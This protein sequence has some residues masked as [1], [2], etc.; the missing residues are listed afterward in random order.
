[1]GSTTPVIRSVTT[2]TYM[3]VSIDASDGNRYDADLS[4]FAGVFC[5]PR[6]SEEWSQVSIDS[7]GLG[8]VWASRFEVHVDQ[9]IGLATH[10]EPIRPAIAPKGT[11]PQ[12]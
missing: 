8:L 3:R 2:P 6:S 12:P 4:S 9:I 11:A 1:M 5:F 7:Y 10:V